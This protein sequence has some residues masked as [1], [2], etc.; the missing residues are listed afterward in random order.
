MLM[1]YLKISILFLFCFFR[2]HGQGGETK[3]IKPH[4]I[5]FEVEAVVYSDAEAQ[6]IVSDRII[7]TFTVDEKCQIKHFE[8]TQGKL[9]SFSEWAKKQSD[10]IIRELLKSS[11]CD[12]KEKR[13]IRFPIQINFQQP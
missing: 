5:N 6:N 11:P 1:Q 7:I 12:G 13:I 3:W 10:V 8:V 2:A 4:A 9:K